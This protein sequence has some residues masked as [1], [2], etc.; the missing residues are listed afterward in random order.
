M[1]V[2][3]ARLIYDD[4]WRINTCRIS[5]KAAWGEPGPPPDSEGAPPHRT[6]SPSE[7]KANSRSLRT[8]RFDDVR[9]RIPPRFHWKQTSS[10]SQR[11]LHGRP[12]C[13]ASVRHSPVAWSATENPA[14]MSLMTFD[15]PTR[16]LLCCPSCL[17]EAS[18]LWVFLKL[19]AR[20]KLDQ[21]AGLPPS[22]ETISDP[23]TNWDYF[24][25]FFYGGLESSS[26]WRINLEP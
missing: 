8:D 15:H 14:T 16:P 22:S 12:S 21:R 7:S 3:T 25:Y 24:Y 18:S 4:F 2:G 20:A 1:S 6:S 23:G 5:A 26:K 17:A 11:P 19:T 10:A 9:L 13:A